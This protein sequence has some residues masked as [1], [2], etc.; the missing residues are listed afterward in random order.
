MGRLREQNSAQADETVSM[1][2]W[3]CAD[4]PAH[5]GG[6]RQREPAGICERGMGTRANS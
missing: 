5:A 3:R 6:Q 4:S 1:D 2:T